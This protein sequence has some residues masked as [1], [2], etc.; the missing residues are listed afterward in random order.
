[1]DCFEALALER[2]RGIS[3]SLFE[4]TENQGQRRAKLVAY[5]AE[6]CRLQPVQLGEFLSTL[7]LLLM[8]A[9]VRYGGSDVVS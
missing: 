1:M 2:L 5:I 8:G 7:S 9:G 4:R 6:E 3:E